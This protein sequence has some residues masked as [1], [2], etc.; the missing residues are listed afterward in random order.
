MRSSPIIAGDNWDDRWETNG[1][2][3]KNSSLLDGF[4]KHLFLFP[5]EPHP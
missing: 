1:G 4:K 3:S 2:K 5:S